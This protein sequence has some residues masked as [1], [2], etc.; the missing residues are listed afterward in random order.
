MRS[1]R[2]EQVT[3]R[4]VL[5]AGGGLLAAA[6]LPRFARAAEEHPPIGTWPAGAEGSSVFIGITP[7]LTGTYAV[8]GED[9][10]NGYKLAIEHINTGHP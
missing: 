8:P 4:A 2:T 5:R 3:R 6:A 7:P 9:E 10:L 1:Y